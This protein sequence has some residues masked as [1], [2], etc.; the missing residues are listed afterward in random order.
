MHLMG[1]GICKWH[2]GT[3]DT[4]DARTILQDAPTSVIDATDLKHGRGIH[5]CDSMDMYVC[6]YLHA[7]W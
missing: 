2:A 4:K 1:M 3:R 6:R 7:T 5:L